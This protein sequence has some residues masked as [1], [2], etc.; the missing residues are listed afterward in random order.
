MYEIGLLIDMVIEFVVNMV[1]LLYK[2]VY[3][4][5]VGFDLEVSC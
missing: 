2:C 4:K 3:I 5:L 1:F